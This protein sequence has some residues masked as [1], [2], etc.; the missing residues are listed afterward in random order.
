MRIID[1]YSGGG[2]VKPAYFFEDFPTYTTI[3]DQPQI[4]D[5]SNWVTGIDR[6]SSL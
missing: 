1:I 5:D 2:T 3:N 4:P 6:K